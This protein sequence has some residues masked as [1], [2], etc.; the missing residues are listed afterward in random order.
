MSLPHVVIDQ[1]NELKQ[2]AQRSVHTVKS[3]QLEALK[4]PS[5][6]LDLM[7]LVQ[8]VFLTQEPCRA[9]AFSGVEA[10]SKSPV[11]CLEAARILAS[12]INQD[13][14][15]LDADLEHLGVLD[16][17]S[18]VKDRGLTT[19]IDSND[20]VRVHATKMQEA[21][22]YLML[23]GPSSGRPLLTGMM[24][25]FLARAL[26]E[27]SFVL[28]HSPSLAAS[29]DCVTLAQATDGMVLVL[30]ASK[31][32][33]AVAIRTVNQ[34]ESAGATILGAVLSDTVQPVPDFIYDRL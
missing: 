9:V 29:S 25:N 6:G 1:S 12:S 32:R 34:L 16:A 15:I 28:V 21:N 31:T 14:L 27:F 13:V 26:K 3:I 11:I 33:K 19:A 5:A 22:L 23:P 30:E 20:S 10:N 18:K 4:R 2:A 8:R 7:N 24:R 17:Y